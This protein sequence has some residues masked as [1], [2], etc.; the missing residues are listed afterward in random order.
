[1]RISGMFRIECVFLVR[2]EQLKYINLNLSL[3]FERVGR[4]CA[5]E[6]LLRGECPLGCS[7]AVCHEPFPACVLVQQQISTTEQKKQKMEKKR[8]K[9]KFHARKKFEKKLF[10]DTT[11]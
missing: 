4:L 7:R 5:A 6:D 2:K 9:T 10:K 11:L 3:P 1:M 8:I